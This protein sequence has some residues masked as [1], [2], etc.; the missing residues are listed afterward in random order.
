VVV[1]LVVAACD[2][3]A[4][5]HADTKNGARFFRRDCARCHGLHGRGDG[6]DA[7]IFPEPPRDLRSGFLV[8]YSN[9]ELV[10]RVRR[11]SVL[12]LALDPE[13]LKARE[14]DAATV[15]AYLRRLPTIDW[16]VVEPGHGLYA[17]RCV[18]CHGVYGKP[19]QKPEGGRDATA[20][21]RDLS[22]PAYQRDLTDERL[23]AVLAEKH[24]PALHLTAKDAAAVGAYVRI[25]SRGYE[26]Y[27]RYCINCHGDTGRADG[28][29]APGQSQPS[30]QFDEAYFG[31]HDTGYVTGRIW[32]M[33]QEK[34]PRMPHLRHEVSET[35]ARAIVDFL[36]QLQQ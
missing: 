21:S 20:A 29:A 1:L 8:Q 18:S 26:I 33:L 35:A 10:R 31:T 7:V 32:H 34:K 3:V 12:D 23:R 36:K 15:A 22:D 17:E 2:F 4:A 28:M 11:G 19:P 16:A 5:A 27:S 30:V 25:L 13:A 14:G 24:A 6:P 9:A